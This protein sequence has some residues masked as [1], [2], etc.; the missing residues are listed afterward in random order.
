MTD[1]ERSAQP[2]RTPRVLSLAWGEMTIEGTAPGKDFV[3]Y[4]GGAHPWDWAAHGT[5]HEPGILPGDVRELLDR[6]AR[7]MVLGLGMDSRLRIAPETRD[8]LRES[9]AEVHAHDTRTAVEV[10][11]A[12]ITGDRPVGALFHSTC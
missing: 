9:G 6:G 8:L 5:R 2:P 1:A 12:L 4:P 3:V 11:H 7:V 10:H